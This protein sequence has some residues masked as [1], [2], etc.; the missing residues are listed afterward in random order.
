MT[1]APCAATTLRADNAQ[2][3]L[4]HLIAE[5]GILGALPALWWCVVFGMMMFART[6]PDA[7]PLSVGL[8]RGILIGFFVASLFGMPAQAMAVVI[9][10][11]VL[12]FWLLLERAGKGTAPA[13]AAWKRP[14]AIAAALLI[15]IHAGA[16]VM[17]ARGDLLP[18]H[19]AQRFDWFYAYGI[20]ELEADPG[21]NPVQ[22][23]WTGEQA[24]VVVPVKG[25]VLKFVAWIDHPDGDENPPHVVVRADS[26]IVHDG[27]LKRS[28]PLFID[29]PATPGKTHMVIETSIDRTYRPAEQGSRD[30]RDLGLSISDFVWNSYFIRS[31][32]TLFLF[33]VGAN[34]VVGVLLHPRVDDACVEVGE[35]LRALENRREKRFLR[36]R[37]RAGGDR[38]QPLR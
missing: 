1:S 4:R 14:A 3:W 17:S 25:K 33:Q 15:V 29:I 11:W 24:L 34:R 31:D 23:R 35:C 5:L 12:A 32:G 27:P 20:G 30:R 6:G 28:A 26:R 7:D 18:R 22:R 38:G 13:G 9:T 8:L 2:A 19:R 21:G 16:T 37:E 10:F 36:Q